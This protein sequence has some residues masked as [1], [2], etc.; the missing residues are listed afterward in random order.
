MVDCVINN[1]RVLLGLGGILGIVL[2]I[3]F[4]ILNFGD[5]TIGPAQAENGSLGFTSDSL[6]FEDIVIEL[7]RTEHNDSEN[8]FYFTIENATD[9]A[10]STKGTNFK[11][12]NNGKNYSSD[13]I[14]IDE[15]SLNPGMSTNAKVLFKMSQSD[16]FEG[17]P[18]M[19]I[20][21]GILFGEKQEFELKK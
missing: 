1:K 12:K 14:T 10:I 19:E 5:T 3:F 16:L 15:D 9:S 18:L 21:R 2:L 8:I 4:S 13:L 17:M 7:L 6:E 20:K 11:I